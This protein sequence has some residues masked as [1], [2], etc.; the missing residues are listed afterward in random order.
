MDMPL[1]PYQLTDEQTWLLEAS[2]YQDQRG[3]M[4]WK[5]WKSS[6]NLNLIDKSEYALIPLL[7]KN[8]SMLGVSD[9]IIKKYRGIR[10]HTWYINNILLRECTKII[11]ELQE[12][13]IQVVLLAEAAMT[14]QYYK[15]YGLCPTRTLSMTVRQV[16]VEDTLTALS[17]LGWNQCS[18][19]CPTAGVLAFRELLILKNNAIPFPLR[20]FSFQET[21]DF[22]LNSVVTEIDSG[23][24]GLTF[25]VLNPTTQLLNLCFNSIN[26]TPTLSLRWIADSLKI[27]SHS[28]DAIDWNR[29]PLLAA[30]HNSTFPLKIAVQFLGESFDAVF[31][32]SFLQKLQDV[33]ISKSEKLQLQLLKMPTGVLRKSSALLYLYLRQNN[34]HIPLQH[35]LSFMAFLK[36]H[37]KKEYVW[38]VPCTGL[39]KIALSIWH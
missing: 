4:A 30:L 1:S 37:W 26:V 21:V 3:L 33:Q 28:T 22:S 38:Q 20:L 34:K 18:A 19:I 14:L 32:E 7:S 5:R 31:P 6:R 23:K 24:E 11:G 8:L 10:L 16:E 2:I 15:D 36:T 35:R 39:K 9:P 17:E 25:S 12:K 27:M 29:L 13:G